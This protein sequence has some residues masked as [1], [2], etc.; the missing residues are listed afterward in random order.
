MYIFYITLIVVYILSVMSRIVSK[1][2][3]NIVFVFILTSVLVILSGLRNNIGDTGTYMESYKMIATNQ[4]NIDLSVDFGFNLFQLLLINIST[5]P[6]ILIFTTSLIINTLN[7]FTFRK[8][9]SLFELEVYIYITSC[10]YL[11][12][13][14]GI[15]QALAAAIIFAATQF[16]INGEFIKYLIVVLIASTI[17]ASAIIMLPIYFIVRSKAWS[18]VTIVIIAISFISFIFF[19]KIMPVAFN[20]LENTQYGHYEEYILTGGSG[21]VNIVRVVIAAIPVILAFIYRCKLE[22]EWKY[23][24]V[25]VNM[26]LI[27]LILYIFSLYNWIFSRFNIYFNLY[28]FVLLPYLIKNMLEKKERDLIYYLFILF[29]FILFI[30]ETKSM[31]IFYRSDYINFIK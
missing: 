25:F 16:I 30:Y 27:N 22:S 14:N 8:Y 28:S 1:N 17:H 13:M 19:Y 21:G 11:V 24:N 5:N 7:I 3:P 9:Y 18:K 31:D 20:M 29:Y 12:T 26:S 23:S 6:Q 4:S 15:R 2:K 10:Y